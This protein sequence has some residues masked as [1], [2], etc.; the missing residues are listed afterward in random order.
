MNITLSNQIEITGPVGQDEHQIITHQFTSI[1][2]AFQEALKFGR[3]VRNIDRTLKLFTE[4]EA[5]LVL[6]IGALAWL[7][8]TFRPD[9]TDLR[10]TVPAFIN[11][12]GEL[13]LYQE[14]FIKLAMQHSNGVMVAATGAGKTV[15]AIAMAAQLQQRT[16]ILVKSKDLAGQWVE[17]IKQFTGLDAGLIGGGKSIEGGQFTIGL[18]QSLVKRDLTQLN[19]GLVIADECHNT[20]AMQAYGVLNGINAR[21]KFGLS[22]TIQRRDKLE[23]MM[24]AA[25]GSVVSEVEASELEGKVL[26]V[27][28][29]TLQLSFNGQ[30]ESWNAF[31]AALAN[32]EARNRMIVDTA[33][34]SSQKMGTIILCAHVGHC[35][36]LGV[37]ARESGLNAL[38]L[39]GQLS[40]KVRAERMAIASESPLIIGTLSLLSEGIDLPHLTALIF[41]SPVSAEPNRENPAATRL[42]QSIGRCRRPYPNK[43]RAFVLDICDRHPFGYSAFKKRMGIYKQQ[44]FEVVAA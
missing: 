6:P 25:L 13:R 8:Q 22:A 40:S 23:F 3:S 43:Q 18:V 28:V 2:P 37:M 29:K 15:S 39:H 32:D 42:M 38:V 1:N 14:R 4:I 34:K 12:N 24:Y 35:E 41:A 44:N 11:F 26:P 27:Q 5:G 17:A 9:V 33:L 30:P 21:Y 19:Y 36:I 7:L 31:L 20:P 10:A 16:L